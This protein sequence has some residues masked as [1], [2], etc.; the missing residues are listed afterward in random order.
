M[1]VENMNVRN[2]KKALAGSLILMQMTTF[3]LP[4]LGATGLQNFTCKQTGVRAVF[5][6]VK[7]G[8]WYRD[9]VNSCYEMGLMV[10]RSANRFDPQGEVTLAEAICFAARIHS[11]Y[12]DAAVEADVAEGT[13]KW[14]DGAVAYAI[15]HGLIEKGAFAD[16]D[17]PATRA[18]L[19]AIIAKALPDDQWQKV[20]EVKSL[21][22]VTV[23]SPYYNEILKLYQAGVLTG[24]DDYGT[25]KCGTG[26]TRA[27]AAA[28]LNRVVIID[29][30]CRLPLKEFAPIMKKY[31]C[32]FETANPAPAEPVNPAPAEPAPV[33]PV[34][35][36]QTPTKPE[37]PAAQPA[38]TMAAYAAEVLSL[39][40]AE[41]QK[42]GLQ[43]LQGIAAVNSAA[44]VRARE[45]EVQFSHTRP[46]GTS[47]F[48]VLEGLNYRTMGENIAMGQ[49]TPQEVM[50]DWMNSSGHRQNI[51]NPSFTGMGVGVY[52]TAAGTL[53][54]V[55]LFVG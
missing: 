53:C 41:R 37:E 51:L 31:E 24:N 39:V 47:P 12:N 11:T 9:V 19:A 5:A 50:K 45:L 33:D 17:R 15:K 32:P 42:A 55:Q 29:N 6:D 46:D 49:R 38:D 36:D 34:P 4:A 22:D 14:Y 10:G 25:F 26:I 28:I 8:Q 18:E 1:E 2:Y 54:W 48:T 35:V 30:R 20:R 23:N 3:S 21:P 27:E 7:E 43:P 44:G 52:K 40:N 16:L 13:G